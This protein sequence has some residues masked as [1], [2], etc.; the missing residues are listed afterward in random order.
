MRRTKI[1]T[2]TALT[3]LCLTA[4]ALTGCQQGGDRADGKPARS[5]PSDTSPRPDQSEEPFAGLTGGEIAERALE[6]TLGASSLRVT[7]DVP[8]ETTGGTL[9]LDMAMDHKGE[10]AGTLG[11]DGGK[12]DL[13]KTGDT[14][15]MR[16]DEAFLRAQGEGESPAEADAAVDMLADKWTSMSAT[17]ED[18]ADIT[19]FCDLD[20]LLGGDERVHSNATRGQTTS[21]DGTPAIVL[22]EKDGKDRYTLYVATEGEPYLLR[23]DSTAASDPGTLT[24]SEHDQPVQA[25][26]PTGEILDLDELA[27]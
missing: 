21:V 15:Y 23:L 6:A 25:K 7:G 14:V 17:G 10:C 12:A 11:M 8:D 26:R 27:G 22:Q 2:L 9:D 13:V 4:A 18:M 20:T 19:G 16:Y 1:T 5:A 24:F 3:T